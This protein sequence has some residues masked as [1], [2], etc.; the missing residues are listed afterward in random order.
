MAEGFE[1]AGGVEVEPVEGGEVSS[2]L[3]P[4]CVEISLSLIDRLQGGAQGVGIGSEVEE[5]G[6]EQP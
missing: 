4:R 5:Q 1:G 2:P 6:V 3:L